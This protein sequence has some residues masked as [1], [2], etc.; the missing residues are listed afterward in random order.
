MFRHLV[1]RLALAGFVTLSYVAVSTPAQASFDV[2]PLVDLVATVDHPLAPLATMPIKVFAGQE[3]DPDTGEIVAL[4]VEERVLPGTAQVAGVSVT[5]VDVTDFHNGELVK[6]TEDYFAQGPEGSVYYLGER[7]DEYD[8]SKI[9]GH[10]G[11]WLT[12]EHVDKPGMFLPA[13]A[14][15]GDTFYQERVSGVAEERFTVIAIGQTLT[16]PAGTFD[17]C[18]RTEEMNL[19]H[20]D[21]LLGGPTEQKVYCPGVGLVREDFPGGYLEL[22]PLDAAHDASGCALMRTIGT[23]M[24]LTGSGNSPIG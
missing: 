5:A 24:A 19:T 2:A 4:R 18:V 12:G 3:R 20:V 22:M 17:G 15:V 13:A 11:T 14:R 8:G 1:P 23:E 21:G 16:T 7:V 6:T 10:E 9:V